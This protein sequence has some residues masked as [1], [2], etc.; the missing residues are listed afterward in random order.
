[1]SF[2]AIISLISVV[3]VHIIVINSAEFFGDDI[4]NISVISK[5]I[6]MFVLVTVP[7]IIGMLLRRFVPNYEPIAR[8]ISIVLF[9]L[10]TV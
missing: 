9:V 5:A 4:Q 6:E 10:A 8:K 7:L 3:T 1:M 2:T